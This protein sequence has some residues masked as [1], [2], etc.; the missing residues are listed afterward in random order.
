MSKAEVATQKSMQPF[1]L[2]F[3]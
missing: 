3:N 2:N 1:T